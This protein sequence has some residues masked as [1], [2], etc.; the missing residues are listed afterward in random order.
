MI[1]GSSLGE[2]LRSQGVG[3]PGEG[4]STLKRGKAQDILGMSGFLFSWR[5]KY[6]KKISGREA[7]KVQGSWAGEGLES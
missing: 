7:P 6:M 4:N 5:S 1:F 3:L 2:C